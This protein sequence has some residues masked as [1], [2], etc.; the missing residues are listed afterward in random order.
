[1][2]VKLLFVLPGISQTIC[3]SGRR[4]SWSTYAR[5]TWRSGK[6]VP[7]GCPNFPAIRWTQRY[8]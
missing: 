3:L 7:A 6:T 2:I 8:R 1:V 4:Q 5:T